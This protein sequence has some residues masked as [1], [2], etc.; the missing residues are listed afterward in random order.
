MG[1]TSEKQEEE[2]EEE[3]TNDEEIGTGEDMGI[4]IAVS[5][6][7][8]QSQ[9]SWQHPRVGCCEHRAG[10]NADGHAARAAM[11]LKSWA[12]RER[13]YREPGK[14]GKMTMAGFYKEP[15][16]AKGGWWRV[17]GEEKEFARDT[18]ALC[19]DTAAF[20]Y[21]FNYVA[22]S[23]DRSNEK[24]ESFIGGR[25]RSVFFCA[26]ITFDAQNYQPD[27]QKTKATGER[28]RK[29]GCEQKQSQTRAE[30]HDYR[31]GNGGLARRGMA[32]GK[33]KSQRPR[34]PPQPLLWSQN[35]L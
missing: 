10:N 17:G 2:V 33:S 4:Y 3:H 1:D 8:Y 32:D 27:G 34:V 19:I 30:K 23:F 26:G 25:H 12:D 9:R 31:Q 13:E 5:A 16:I 21:V 22:D 15:G 18:S 6:Y 24:G 14:R 20:I 29:A 35:L 28:D 7:G 11:H